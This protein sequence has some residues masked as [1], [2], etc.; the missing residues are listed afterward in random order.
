[1][2]AKWYTPNLGE[3][4]C[5]VGNDIVCMGFFSPQ[6]EQQ[7]QIMKDYR[8]PTPSELVWFLEETG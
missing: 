2:D 7:T 6:L 1:M 5:T 3:L 4:Y 8:S